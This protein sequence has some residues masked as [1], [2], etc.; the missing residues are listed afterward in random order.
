MIQHSVAPQ[1]TYL[2]VRFVVKQGSQFTPVQGNTAQSITGTTIKG[3]E[4]SS[5]PWGAP[6]VRNSQSEQSNCA[7]HWCCALSPK[8]KQ[9]LRWREILGITPSSRK[10]KKLSWSDESFIYLALNELRYAHICEHTTG[11]LRFCA[12]FTHF[13]TKC[14][15]SS[16]FTRANKVGGEQVAQFCQLLALCPWLLFQLCCHHQ[17]CW[18]GREQKTRMRRK[19]NLSSTF[20][21]LCSCKMVI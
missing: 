11:T 16:H 18:F 1:D 17:Q 5:L 20:Q 10:T 8:T 7:S 6:P 12:T 13:A 21:A 2:L 4:L 19:G 3:T 14:C 15:S 9:D